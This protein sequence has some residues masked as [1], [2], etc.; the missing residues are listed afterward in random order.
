M[1]KN[2]TNELLNRGIENIYP[3]KAYLESRIAK[4]EKLTIYLGVD[5]TGPT[6]HLGHAIPLLK[7]S[8]FQK[9]G[10]K[11]ILLMGDFTAMI[12]DPTD[13][14]TARVPLTHKQVMANLKNYKKQA[15]SIISF[16]GKN[17]AQI[18]FN[19][20]WLGK[21]NFEDVL[22]LASN[23]TVQQ[24]LER[25]MF[26]KRMEEGKPIFIHEF[27]YPLMQ[28]YDSVAMD[29]DGEIGGN[30]QTFNMLQGR[31]LMK[32]LKNKEKFVIT[33]K[34]L[35]DSSGKKMGKTEGNMVALS[36]TPEEMYGKVMSWTDGMILPGFELCTTVSLED[37]EAMATDIAKGM[38]PRDLKMRLA[39][40]VVNTFY[41]EKKA[42]D[43]E[44]NFISTFQKS[45]IPEDLPEVKV[46]DGTLLVD[47]LLA[48]KIIASKTEFRRLVDEGAITNLDTDKKVD[49]HT[50]HAVSAVYRIGKKRFCKIKIG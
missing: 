21:M 39:R 4:G 7:L 49:S 46:G 33:V 9:A 22:S 19:S 40:A 48:N 37:M 5:P 29:I 25:D 24:M 36:D 16:S 27:M 23:M 15:S 34:L 38:N 50:A 41:G 32:T 2:D 11:I 47:V 6:L 43:A 44:N 35:E 8:E 13:K 26:S 42:L 28:G 18:K 30:D 14:G 12:G 3:S 20:K 1:I 10:H 45:E 17:A 31:N